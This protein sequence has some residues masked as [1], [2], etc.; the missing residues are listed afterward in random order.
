M[1]VYERQDLGANFGA[2]LSCATNGSRFLEEW[3]VDFSKAR[4][5]MLKAPIRHNWPTGEVC[6]AHPLGDYRQRFGTDS[7]NFHR[8]DLHQHLKQV[9][10]ILERRAYILRRRRMCRS[11]Q[12]VAQG[13]GP[14]SYRWKDNI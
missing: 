7:N 9:A 1:G 13:G 14:G 5:V 8:I 6:G 2:S 4:P 10:Y 3:N 11:A 12:A